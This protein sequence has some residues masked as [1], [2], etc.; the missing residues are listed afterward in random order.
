MQMPI[1]RRAKSF[2]QKGL[3]T[4]LPVFALALESEFQD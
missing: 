1:A 2:S 4:F 3:R